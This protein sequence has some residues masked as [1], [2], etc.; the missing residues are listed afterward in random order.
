MSH[1]TFL[2]NS[3]N[4]Y[5]LTLRPPF[6]LLEFYFLSFPEL[7]KVSEVNYF[8]TSFGVNGPNSS[9]SILKFVIPHSF[10]PFFCP[11]FFPSLSK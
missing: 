9:Y 1:V 3:T 11:S 10:L 7:K 5:I 6:V 2:L 8:L 4:P